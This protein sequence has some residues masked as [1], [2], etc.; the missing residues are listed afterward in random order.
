[1]LKVVN[2]QAL[3]VWIFERARINAFR[4]NVSGYSANAWDVPTW[5]IEQ[6]QIGPR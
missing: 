2:D 4:S 3:D 6:W 5:N 1:V